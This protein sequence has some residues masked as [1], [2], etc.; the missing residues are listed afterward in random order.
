MA[1]CLDSFERRGYTVE[2]Q[3]RQGK[4]A[5]VDELIIA[6]VSREEGIIITHV[7][8]FT[9]LFVRPELFI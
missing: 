5:Y 1:D 7:F 9:L 8:Y 6:N 3:E 4:E 2:I